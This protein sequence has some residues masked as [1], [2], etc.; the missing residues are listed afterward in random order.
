MRHFALRLAMMAFVFYGSGLVAVA[1]DYVIHLPP[2]IPVG[3]VQMTH[4][5]S[6]RNGGF[7]ITEGPSKDSGSHELRIPVDQAETLEVRLYC[8]GYQFVTIYEPKLNKSRYEA[9]V[10]FLKARRK[11]I[12]GKIRNFGLISFHDPIVSVG[13]WGWAG[14]THT[15]IIDGGPPLVELATVSISRSGRF[16]VELPDLA[17]DPVWAKTNPEMEELMFQVGAKEP[18]NG[19]IFLHLKG[20]DPYRVAIRRSYPNPSVFIAKKLR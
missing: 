11:I 1:R 19:L 17:R 3:K 8:P 10:S 4:F 9:T 5:T 2:D 14:L 20:G 12:H 16:T 6:G 15:N 7:L 18:V 13:Y